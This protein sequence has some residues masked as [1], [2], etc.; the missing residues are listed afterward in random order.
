VFGITLQPE[1]E[2]LG[3]TG[4]LCVKIPLLQAIKYIS[5]YSKTVREISIKS[6]SRKPR[7][8]PTVQVLKKLSE[9]MMGKT[10]L[11]KYDDPW[12]PKITIHIGK[13][14]IPNTLNDMGVEINIITKETAELL[15][16]TNIRPTPIVLKLVD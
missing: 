14:I 2:F 1:F 7:D 10:T 3:E 8:S 4:N 6:S 5:V 11:V 16:L 13:M 9:L 15:G 12:N